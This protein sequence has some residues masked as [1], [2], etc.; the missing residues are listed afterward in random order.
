MSSMKLSTLA[1]D[2][3]DCL[4]EKM[5]IH[6]EETKVDW[7]NIEKLQELGCSAMLSHT[8]TGYIGMTLILKYHELYINTPDIRVVK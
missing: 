4:K 6:M 1:L 8:S 3:V 7:D 5:K 2:T